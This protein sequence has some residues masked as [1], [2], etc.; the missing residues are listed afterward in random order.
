MDTSKN[1]R[2]GFPASRLSSEQARSSPQALLRCRATGAHVY[3]GGSQ[4]LRSFI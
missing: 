2:S 3:D 1:H 4:A